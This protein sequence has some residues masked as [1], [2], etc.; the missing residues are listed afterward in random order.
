MP[1]TLSPAAGA[2]FAA[3]SSCSSSSSSS[4]LRPVL[5]AGSHG[6]GSVGYSLAS[7]VVTADMGG[8]RFGCS[9]THSSPIWMH[10]STSAAFDVSAID[11]SMN[12]K[13]SPSFHSLHA[14][15]NGDEFVEV[16]LGV[17][18]PSVLL[19]ADDL[20]HQHAEA[21]HVGFRR[22]DPVHGVFR[23]HVPTA[24]NQSKA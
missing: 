17:V 14:C 15:R 8:L 20:E 21:E 7:I 22:E 2:A 13:L 10:L 1:L 19:P 4:R 5:N 9:C 18:E 3:V 11:W 6:S 16:E 24:T 12:S 23:G